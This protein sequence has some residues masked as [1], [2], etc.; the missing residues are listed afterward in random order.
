MRRERVAKEAMRYTKTALLLFGAALTLGLVVKSAEISG[1]E[2][3][4]AAAI[5]A[6]IL[7][8]PAAVAADLWRRLRRVRPAA[9][10]K[11]SRKTPGRRTPPSR[12]P[13][14]ARRRARPRA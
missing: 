11:R 13:E 5:A 4:A 3:A 2:R 14:V 8:V 10:K 7:L 1:W 12:R 6:A 9:S